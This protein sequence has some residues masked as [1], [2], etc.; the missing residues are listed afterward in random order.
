MAIFKKQNEEKI[1]DVKFNVHKFSQRIKPLDPKDIIIISC[2]SEFGCEVMGAMY[3]V[4][5]IIAENPDK[6]YVV[7]GWYGRSYLYRHLV[8]EF[9]ETGEEVQWLRDY[10]L[11]FHNNSKNLKII[12]KS[13]SEFGKVIT[14]DKLGRIAVGNECQE[15]F[16]FWGK[17][18]QVEFCP[19]CD[20]KNILKGL[21][22][23]I[24]YWKKE[25]QRYQTQVQKK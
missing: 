5:K 16:N 4:P 6:Y 18:G 3:C 15:C 7:M 23:D 21:F 2:F 17:V 12:E 25:L 11:A 20:S 10:A 8:D 1:V 19:K 14:A 22:S 13:V 9:W 24:P